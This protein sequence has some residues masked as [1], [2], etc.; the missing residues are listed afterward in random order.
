MTYTF[1]LFRLTI[2]TFYRAVFFSIFVHNCSIFFARNLKKGFFA[3]VLL[4]FLG[5]G[6]HPFRPYVKGPELRHHKTI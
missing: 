5:G 4:L 6:G 2:S 3:V 1:L